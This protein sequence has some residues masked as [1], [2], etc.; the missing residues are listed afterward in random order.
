MANSWYCAK[1]R[2]LGAEEFGTFN[3]AGVWFCNECIAAAA[4][5]GD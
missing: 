3:K 5:K 1:C 2:K 4:K